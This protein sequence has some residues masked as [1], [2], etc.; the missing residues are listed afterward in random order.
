MNRRVVAEGPGGHV[1]I[2][3]VSLNE[4]VKHRNLP[5]MVPTMLC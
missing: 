2:G 4:E 5:S 1:L 3:R